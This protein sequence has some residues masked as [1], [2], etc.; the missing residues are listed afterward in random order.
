MLNFCVQVNIEIQ[1]KGL[2]SRRK[3]KDIPLYQ[4]E[5]FA[6]FLFHARPPPPKSTFSLVFYM[7]EILV[8]CFLSCNFL[9]PIMLFTTGWMKNTFTTLPR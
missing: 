8:S 3:Q 6:G 1:G 9:V 2:L 7:K 5:S 4:T